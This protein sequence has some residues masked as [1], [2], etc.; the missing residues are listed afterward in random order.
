MAPVEVLKVAT[1]PFEGQKPGTSGLRKPVPVF[2]GE[3]YAANFVQSTLSCISEEER[4]RGNHTVVVG[5][6]GRYYM[7]EAVQLIV[8]MCAA[9]GLQK[10]I[11]GQNGIF[12]TPAVS[13]V[14]RKRSAAGG[15][16]L[17]ASHNPGGPNGDFGIKYNIANGGPA[18]EGVT[19]AIFNYTKTIK[20]YL[21]CPD[22]TVDL[23]SLGTQR[24]EVAG[25]SQPF[26]VE[27]VD[28][29]DDYLQM[30]RD[31]FDFPTIK[32]L[33]ATIK[34]RAD[35]MC[36]VMG[37]YV[38]RV[39]CQELGASEDAAVR[40]DPKD[41]FGGHHPDPNLTYAADLVNTMK[42][43]DYELG[44]AFDGDGDR[45]MILG[46]GG[47]FVTPSDSVAVIA[48]NCD[49]IPYFKRSGGAKGFARSMPTGGALDRVAEGLGVPMFEV[50]TGW[51]FFGNLMDAGKLSICGEESFGTGSDHIREK[52]GFW[53]V[54]SWLSIMA[55]RKASV[56]EIVHA[57][58]AKYGRNF[59]TRYDYENVDA[60]PA[61]QM[62]ANVEQL[63]TA[64]DFVGK[65]F[66][67]GDKTY[68]VAKG[69][70]FKYTDPI[71]GSV[72]TKQG[73]RIVFEDGS[74]VI[75]RLSGTGS[76]GA[77]IRM[78]VDSY[79]TDAAKQ[80]LD[81]QVMLKPLVEIALKL[82]QLRELTG[83]DQP[84]VIT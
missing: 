2:K 56:E 12:S 49:C 83:R 28:S 57:H 43:G 78:Y 22:I 33:L 20:E 24:F 58:W 25:Q 14:I 18:P 21:I 54:M 15:I 39:L 52:D 13:C 79:E 1:S 41:D 17:T 48:A 4:K 68:K 6:D 8:R 61:N 84:T 77:T 26:V 74:R 50:P 11:V 38:K 67:H 16:I 75:F 3:H 62:M 44:V 46:R 65:E 29:V 59:F 7:K 10:V 42:T 69:D 34:I 80:K 45:N 76:V 27:V 36:G 66:S 32:A 35:A 31:I 51:K 55:A 63:I 70:N 72:S 60:A 81:A 53:A 64:A 82:S 23:A 5:G 9:N 40:C 37:P 73:L 30:C 19:N 71:D 47:F